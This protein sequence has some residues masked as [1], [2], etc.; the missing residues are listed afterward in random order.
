MGKLHNI[1]RGSTLSGPVLGLFIALL[2]LSAA[3]TECPSIQCTW[4][5][6]GGWRVTKQVVIKAIA[7]A[8]FPDS[9][10][11]AVNFLSCRRTHTH[12]QTHPP[13]HMFKPAP[14]V[15]LFV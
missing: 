5:V 13:T 4:S 1:I 2:V 14:V 10:I 12:T 7:Q 8:M 15:G 6:F 9:E 3:P 11:D